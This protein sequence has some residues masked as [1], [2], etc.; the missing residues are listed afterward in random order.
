MC[1]YDALAK[2]K[3]QEEKDNLV[4]FFKLLDAK[5][6]DR[7]KM[8]LFNKQHTWSEPYKRGERDYFNCLTC[9]IATSIPE[10]KDKQ[11][12]EEIEKAQDDK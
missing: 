2:C 4:Q 1:I 6:A 8:C 10:E 7:R 3:T 12:L 11:L 5:C 9:N